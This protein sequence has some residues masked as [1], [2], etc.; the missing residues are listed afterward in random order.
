VLILVGF[1]SFKLSAMEGF[2]EFL[3]VLISVD[4][5]IFI[6]SRSETHV[7][8]PE[9]HKELLEV[10]LLSESKCRLAGEL[11]PRVIRA[12]RCAAGH[13]V[14][15][16]WGTPF[17]RVGTRRIARRQGFGAVSEGGCLQ[18]TPEVTSCVSTLD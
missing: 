6:I 14:R 8:G 16:L 9:A 10:S 1:R 12:E 4:L 3:E 17:R 18:V 7:R 15:R 5:K 13:G 2:C 11:F